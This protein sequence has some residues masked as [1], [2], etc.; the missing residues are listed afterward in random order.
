MASNPAVR[1]T[2]RHG[3][4][5]AKWRG[6]AWADPQRRRRPSRSGGRSRPPPN[7]V[8]R[9]PAG[10]LPGAGRPVPSCRRKCGNGAWSGC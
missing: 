5:R 10:W 2:R 8:R 3:Q 7:T 9:G 6:Q 4:T 1:V